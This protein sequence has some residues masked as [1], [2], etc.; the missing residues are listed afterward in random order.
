MKDELVDQCLHCIECDQPFTYFA[1]EQDYYRRN[2]LQD[3]KRCPRHRS[4]GK[5]LERIPAN[6]VTVNLSKN[7]RPHGEFSNKSNGLTQGFNLDCFSPEQRKIV[8]LLLEQIKE[9]RSQR[10]NESTGPTVTQSKRTL[11]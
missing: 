4:N 1:T 9:L 2:G 8:E 5:K 7:L 10:K 6:K 11:V 3:P